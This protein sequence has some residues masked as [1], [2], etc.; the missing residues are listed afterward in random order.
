MSHQCLIRFS[1]RLFIF[2]IS[3]GQLNKFT[4]VVKGWQY[5]WFVLTP[6]TGNLE[7]YL[8]DEGKKIYHLLPIQSILR[9]LKKMF[10]HIF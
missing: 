7:Y 8:M 10:F 6:E 5:R 4:N 3:L 1:T 2:S 9:F